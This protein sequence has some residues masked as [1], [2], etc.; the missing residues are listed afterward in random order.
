MVRE[1]GLRDGEE[2]RGERGRRLRVW[3]GKREGEGSEGR[4]EEGEVRVGEG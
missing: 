4:K 3:E 2:R 1:G